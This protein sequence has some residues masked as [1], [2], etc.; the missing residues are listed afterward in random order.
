VKERAFIADA[1]EAKG[2]HDGSITRIVRVVSDSLEWSDSMGWV[3]NAGGELPGPPVAYLDNIEAVIQEHSPFSVPGDRLFVQEDFAVIQTGHSTINAVGSK[4]PYDPAALYRAD[5]HHSVAEAIADT[6]IISGVEGWEASVDHWRAA[7]T[8]P[9]WAS[10]TLL[11]VTDVRVMRVQEIGDTTKH[12]MFAL[13]IALGYPGRTDIRD[14]FYIEWFVRLWNSINE[15]HPWTANPWIF[16]GTVE[17][18]E[19]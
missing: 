4:V 14:R 5:G 8:M 6:V 19:V 7:E 15:K 13:C 1:R 9:R 18:K 17:K 3:W 10:R 2:L 11:D 16:L 12:D